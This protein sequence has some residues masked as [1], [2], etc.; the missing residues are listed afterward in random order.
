MSE[1]RERVRYRVEHSKI[2]F[3]SMR[4][5]VIS[6]VWHSKSERS[7]WFFLGHD[8]AIQT[9]SMETVIGCVFF[10]FESWQIQNKYGPSAI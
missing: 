7:D 2:K 10:V 5:Y 6:S 3:I 1:H 4:R 9:I 8:F